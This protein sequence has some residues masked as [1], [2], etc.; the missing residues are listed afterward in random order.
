MPLI[1]A[2]GDSALKAYRGNYDDVPGEI[3]FGDL[4]NQ[5][6]QPVFVSSIQ[7][8]DK[9]NYKVIA[10]VLEGDARMFIF[11]EDEDEIYVPGL[12]IP[13]NYYNYYDLAVTTQ[14]V[15]PGARIVLILPILTEGENIN[16]T[17]FNETYNNV[18]KIGRSQFSWR[19]TTQEFPPAQNL[20][21]EAFLDA[22]LNS[23]VES[24][25]YVVSGILD[26]V[27]YTARINSEVGRFRI[28]S[29]PL[30]SSAI[31][32]NGDIINLV[33]QNTGPTQLTTTDVNF[34]ISAEG[35]QGLSQTIWEVTTTE[36]K[37]PIDFQ[38]VD[39]LNAEFGIDTVSNEYIVSLLTEGAVYTAEIIGE[40]GFLTVNSGSQ[41]KS[42]T[43]NNNDSLTLVF[44]TPLTELTRNTVTVKISTSLNQGQAE[45]TWAVTT[46]QIN[47]DVIFTPTN[48]TNVT[49]V[50]RNTL[51]TSNQITVTEID[52]NISLPVNVSN[53]DYRLTRGGIIVKDYTS[54]IEPII[55]NDQINLRT[56]SSGAFSSTVSASLNI[57][58]RNT[59][60]SVTTAPPPPPPPPPQFIDT[61][62]THFTNI[63]IVWTPRTI[64]SNITPIN[65]NSVTPRQY[66]IDF[67]RLITSTF[68]ISF[69]RQG[70]GSGSTPNNFPT[71]AVQEFTRLSSTRY[72]L[73]F[74][75]TTTSPFSGGFFAY[76]YC[77][78]FT[79][80]AYYA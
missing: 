50:A 72:R 11:T 79:I 23:Q 3:I 1:G 47:L 78:G 36:I 30:N 39:V 24:E 57:G 74:G 56:T 5:F 44:K 9:I 61:T 26:D 64:I 7:V 75:G 51:V 40:N 6:P 42:A 25:E 67:N 38:F 19:I 68:V 60:W 34:S 46:K 76:S 62:I 29:G 49:G 4:L 32:K 16:R 13:D 65:G 12:E 27:E 28:N 80:R 66:L 41:V 17:V 52:Q 2:T 63:S 59:T 20:S 35:G 33:L 71:L 31:V 15:R 77:R 70:A 53:A 55:N 10:E 54:S 22:P 37:P 14:T 21:F 45:T 43:V 48:F 18:I 8:V 69:L 58:N 73:V